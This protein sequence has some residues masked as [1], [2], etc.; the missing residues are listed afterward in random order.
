MRKLRIV[1]LASAVILTSGGGVI[2]DDANQRVQLEVQAKHSNG[3]DGFNQN[4][5]VN[6]VNYSCRFTG[7]T[8]G[9]GGV[10]VIRGSGKKFISV[11]LLNSKSYLISSV[12]FNGVGSEEF[13]LAPN[14]TGNKIIIDFRNVNDVDVKYSVFVVDAARGNR[15]DCDPPIAN[16]PP[17]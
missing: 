13:K 16:K 10:N 3:E 15:I 4:Q 2:A 7:G 17:T 6:G 11:G 14:S 5:T 9:A 8:D 12:T 1:V